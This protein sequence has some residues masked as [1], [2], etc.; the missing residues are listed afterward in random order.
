MFFHPFRAILTLRT[1]KGD[2]IHNGDL[3]IAEELRVEIFPKSSCLQPTKAGKNWSTQTTQE[4]PSSISV[5]Q[6]LISACEQKKIRDCFWK[7]IRAMLHRA[8]GKKHTTFSAFLI[9]LEW[10]Q[11]QTTL[12]TQF[13]SLRSYILVEGPE[14]H[15]HWKW[16][17]RSAGN[18][19]EWHDFLHGHCS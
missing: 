16:L 8:S 2:L 4:Y 14:Q 6:S 10:I 15:N 1:T 11:P 9:D 13:A 17:G 12:K 3:G 5:K 18:M 7:P 19:I